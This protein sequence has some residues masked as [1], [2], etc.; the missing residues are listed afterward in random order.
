M[1]YAIDFH[2]LV[3]LLYP[4]AVTELSRES[5]VGSFTSSGGG[6]GGARVGGWY[7]AYSREAIYSVS[8]R[9]SVKV[10]SANCMPSE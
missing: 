5:P 4:S 1:I 8:E 9:E 10:Y 6:E 3:C 2:P 7:T